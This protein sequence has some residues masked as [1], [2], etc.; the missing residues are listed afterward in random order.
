MSEANPFMVMIL[1]H[2]NFVSE[3][4]E[5]E[6]QITPLDDQ[7]NFGVGDVAILASSNAPLEADFTVVKGLDPANYAETFPDWE[8]RMTFNAHVLCEIF[9]R[10]DTELSI[11]WVHRL[12]LLPIKQ[13]RYKELKTWRKK[14]FPED[15]PEWVMK[16]FR[17]YTDQLAERAPDKV[18]VAV[19]CSACGKRNV[20]L[21]VV[22]RLEYRGRAGL[23]RQG[24]DE[25]HVTLH[26]PETTSTHQAKL[27]CSDCLVETRLGDDSWVLPNVSN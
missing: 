14:G 19:T 8:E 5:V 21:V 9:S 27:V 2:N 3:A 18:P 23:M 25:R 15:P 7:L 22:R 20:E 12:K 13:Y 16:I 11:G 6:A 1:E 4:Q 26:D 10:A 17:N 24:E